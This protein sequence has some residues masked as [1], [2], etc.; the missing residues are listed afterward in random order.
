MFESRCT[1]PPPIIYLPP[2]CK[3]NGCREPHFEGWRPAGV[4]GKPSEFSPP[5]DFHLTVQADSP[6]QLRQPHSL[7]D[8]LH[9][10]E[11]VAEA[12]KIRNGIENQQVAIERRYD[13][14]DPELENKIRS[15]DPDCISAGSL[16]LNSENF[17]DAYPIDYMPRL[18]GR[19]GTT[20]HESLRVE[21]LEAI[22][23]SL[24]D[25]PSPASSVEPGEPHC[26]YEA[27]KSTEGFLGGGSAETGLSPETGDGRQLLME[28]L[29]KF[30]SI[31]MRPT[32]SN[33][34]S[35]ESPHSLVLYYSSFYWRLRGDRGA[36]H[37]CLL[38]YLAS[39]EVPPAHAGAARLQLGILHLKAGKYRRA[40][41]M[42]ET[43][44]QHIAPED[45]K[46]C[47]A[48]LVSSC[49]C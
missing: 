38:A 32:S 27:T 48:A 1:G 43:A 45:C 31:R 49:S 12:K 25:S 39:D 13:E 18:Y 37:K 19:E 5:F 24:A 22:F 23:A 44:T 11:W 26:P 15:T 33:K 35:S 3:L 8:F 14:D 2:G 10:I 36:A 16:E 20:T 4:C 17:I 6:Y 30:L 47:Y 28:G 42:L 29:A 41:E 21:E 46:E 7:P 40:V 9:Q 34:Q